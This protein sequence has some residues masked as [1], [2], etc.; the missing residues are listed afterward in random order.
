MTI[1]ATENISGM[2]C[3]DPYAT[4]QE[5]DSNATSTEGERLCLRPLLAESL[6]G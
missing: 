5:T 1:P 2:T 3:Y 4:D 6:S